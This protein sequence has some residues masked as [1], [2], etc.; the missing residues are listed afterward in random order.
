[1]SKPS[2]LPQQSTPFTGIL[3]GLGYTIGGLTIHFS[4]PDGEV[5]AGLFGYTGNSAALRNV[6]LTNVAVAVNGGGGSSYCLGGLAGYNGGAIS[7]CSS[8]GSVNI[9]VSGGSGYNVLGGLTGYNDAVVSI[10][11]SKGS[12]SANSNGVVYMGGFIGYNNSSE[13]ISSCYYDQHTSNVGKAAAGTT[14]YPNDGVGY[15]ENTTAGAVN[16][17]GMT[18]AEMMDGGNYAD[19]DF[20][21]VWRIYDGHSY[22]LLRAFLQKLTVAADSVTQTYEGIAYTDAPPNPTYTLADGTELT[23]LEGVYGNLTYGTATDAGTYYINRFILH[24]PEWVRY[25][26]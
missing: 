21:G 20:S 11:Y 13:T 24:R 7:N 25:H 12:V 17:T 8:M 3:D 6:R 26:L 22:P 19:W 16:V 14:T 23:S 18:T 15:D 1:M 2:P 9:E 5:Y 10:S 4:D